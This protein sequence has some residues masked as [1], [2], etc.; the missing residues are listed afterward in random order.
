MFLIVTLV[1]EKKE[2]NG[3]V[4]ESVECCTLGGERKMQNRAII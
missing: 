3:V 1:K 2:I 4:A